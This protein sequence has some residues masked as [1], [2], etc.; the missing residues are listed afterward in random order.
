MAFL[1]LFGYKKNGFVGRFDFIF[2]R[3]CIEGILGGS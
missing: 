2:F 3:G 1:F